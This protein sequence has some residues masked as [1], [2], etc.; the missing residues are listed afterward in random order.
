M[1][2]FGREIDDRCLRCGSKQHVA[3]DCQRP[4]GFVFVKNGRYLIYQKSHS[5]LGVCIEYN[6]VSDPTIAN[7]FGHIPKHL[8]YSGVLK[9]AEQV[10]AER[11]TV[12]YGKDDA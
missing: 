10:P 4:P 6:W 7:V 12:V 8:Y 2:V 3:D 5:H 1:G 9:G 11:V